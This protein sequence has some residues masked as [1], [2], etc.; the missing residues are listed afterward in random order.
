MS[1]PFLFGGNMYNCGNVEDKRR[2][3][4]EIDVDFDINFDIDTEHYYITH[5]DFPFMKVPWNGFDRSVVDH[6]RK[7]VYINRNG[8]ILDEIDSNNSKVDKSNENR[9]SDMAR[10]LAKDIRKPLLKEVYGI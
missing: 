8:N 6:I 5:K 9:I 10:Q 7:V 1:L 2:L 4:K 3:L